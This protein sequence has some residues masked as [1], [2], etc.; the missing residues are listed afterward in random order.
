MSDL[1]FEYANALYELSSKEKSQEDILASLK[2]FDEVL[3]DEM[4]LKFFKNPE[5]SIDVKK[6][7]IDKDIKDTLFKHFLFVL[8]DNRRIEIIGDIAKDFEGIY[9]ISQ[10]LKKVKVSSNKELTKDYLLKL[11]NNLESKLKS[12]VLIENVIDNNITAGIRIEYDSNLIDLTVDKKLS[13]LL[14]ALKE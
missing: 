6:S 5:I 13:D 8:L 11:K 12:K 4:I 10:K 2:L 1:S 14:V 7:F 3:K 9:L